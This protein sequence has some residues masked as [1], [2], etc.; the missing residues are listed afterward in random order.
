MAETIFTSLFVE[1]T[2]GIARR[3]EPVQISIPFPCGAVFSPSSLVLRAPGGK[4]V[5]LQ[6]QPLLRWYDNSI[7]WALLDFWVTVEPYGKSAYELSRTSQDT[8]TGPGVSVHWSASDALI[9]DTGVASFFLNRCMFRPFDRVVIRDIDVI[10]KTHGG[11][12]LV[13][14]A[15]EYYEPTIHDVRIETTGAIRTALRVDG[16][17][18]SR[19][20]RQL[21]VFVARLNFYTKSNFVEIELTLRNPRA[22]HH[23]GGLWDLGDEGSVY[24][25]DFSLLTTLAA[26]SDAS[27]SWTMSSSASLA[28]QATQQLEIYQDSSGGENW[29][30]TNHVNRFGTI[31]TTFRGYRVMA[32]HKLVQEGNRCAPNTQISANGKG[33]AGTIIEFWQN[34]PKAITAQGT[35]LC[36]SLFPHQYRDV[37]ELQGGEQKTH[38]MFL[39]FAAGSEEPL[40]LGWT[41]SRLRP[42]VQPQ[43]YTLTKVLPYFLPR[44]Q[45]PD[46]PV[47]DEMNNLIES[48]VH[49]EQTF[50]ARREII[51]EYGWRHFGDLYA[52]HEAVG[53]TG[54]TP[55]VAHYNN[56]YDVMYGAIIQYLRG[57]DA[58]WFQLFHEL[59]RHVID[60]DIYHT[61][62]D[63][64]AYNGG[65]FWH[66]A[67]YS[68]AAT[69]THRTYSRDQAAPGHAPLQS[70]GPSSSH[71]Y[72][73]G[74]LYYYLLTGS[75]AAAE[76][77]RELANWVI[78]MDKGAEGILT[79]FDKRPTGLASRSVSRDY[80][81]P[82]R[83]SANSLNTLLDAWMLTG[84]G[85]YQAKAEELILRCIHPRDDIAARGLDD[86]ENRWSYTIF[87][88]GLGKYL[89]CKAER[90]DFDFAYHYARESLLRYARWMATHE[91]P[92]Q[93]VLHKV[94]IPTETWP[95]QDIRK[96]NV[97]AFAAKYSSEPDRHVFVTKAGEFFATCV[98]DLCSFS[99]ARLTR[100]LVLL[101]TNGFMQSYFLQHPEETAPCPAHNHDF[102]HPCAFTPQ[103]DELHQLRQMVQSVFD[104]LKLTYRRFRILTHTNRKGENANCA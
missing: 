48:I 103:L 66:T 70:G 100:P 76:A 7:R 58:A 55:R 104:I 57:G 80:H 61:R 38:T 95:A 85:R 50:F 46:S 78:D 72:T 30:S 16:S 74:L 33:V 41:H 81:G 64:A 98:H 27:I 2:V 102:G 53:H 91:V 23:P 10:D 83:G 99:T 86:I 56:Q 12:T 28:S 51:D 13:D 14:A 35:N 45:E 29:H 39:A 97:F 37:H 19:Q 71:N 94:E 73:T 65:M 49:G 77:V 24:I 1:E 3:A 42:Y 22:A 43:W 6:V 9:I 69:A 62:E 18:T 84:D 5:P 82:G 75:S 11:L 90:K 36:L 96:S 79:Y 60:I 87:L 32:D 47:L 40:D 59:A 17:L 93:Q 63:R 34:F 92:Y 21:A 8:T 31:T 67:H 52:D 26:E 54:A 89:D 88:Q 68:D 44:K 15:G 101:L 20:S 4:T 25:R